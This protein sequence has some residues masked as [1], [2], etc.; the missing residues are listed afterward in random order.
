MAGS[1]VQ[2]RIVNQASPWVIHRRG[3][4]AGGIDA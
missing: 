4:I 2:Y 3:G 1:L